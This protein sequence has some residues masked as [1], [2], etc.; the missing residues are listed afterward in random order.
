MPLSLIDAIVPS[1]AKWAF[2][3]RR[4]DR[5]I[6]EGISRD[7]D[8]A[9][10][11]DLVMVR[12]AEIGHH[13]KVQLATGRSSLSYVDDIIVASVGDRYAP[14]QFEGVA[15]IS[16]DAADLLAAGG[17]IGSMRDAHARMAPPTKVAP[18][19]LLTDA[20]GQVVNLEDFA[21]PETEIPDDVTVIGVFG[22][23]M[24]A[25]K[26]TAAVSLA[27]GLKQAGYRVAGVKTT[28]TGAFGDYNA[29][30]DAGIDVADFTDAGMA[31]TYRVPI[32][33]LERAFETLVGSAAERGAE[34][35]VVEFA[36]GVFQDEIAAI[37]DESRIKS[38]LDAVLFAASDALSAAGGA[39][40][41]GENGLAPFAISGIVSSSPLA[42]RE[43]ERATGLQVLTRNE[44]LSADKVSVTVPVSARAPFMAV[45]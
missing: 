21:L 6:V 28:G 32:S 13:Q 7:F 12:I 17:V 42:A 27:Y 1:N 24:N 30:H 11:G 31:S 20:S 4:V 3:T 36:D 14:D 10:P 40:V 22:T 15:E 26:T 38:R 34:V 44:L 45:A 25:G 9:R 37:L 5:S 29:F 16:E 23:S 39:R 43:A 18:L 2:T 35:V 33:R 41:L 19:G 8:Q